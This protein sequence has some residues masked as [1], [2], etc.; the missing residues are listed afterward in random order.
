L[1]TF[2]PS[3]TYFMSNDSTHGGAAQRSFGTT[4]GCGTGRAT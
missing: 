4:D 1:P 3:F 2:F